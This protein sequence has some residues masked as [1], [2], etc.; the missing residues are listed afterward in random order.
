MKSITWINTIFF[1]IM[2][3]INMIANMM[4]LGGNTTGEVSARY[5][6]LFTPAPFTFMI[7]GVI[8][9]FMLLFIIAQFM[10]DKDA[11]DEWYMAKT[12]GIWFVI[13]CIFNIAWIV[14]WHFDFIIASV[15]IIV[16]L[17]ISLIV[18]STTF[19]RG[20]YHGWRLLI[21][22]GFQIYLGWICAATIANVS[23]MLKKIEWKGFGVNDQF[24]TILVLLVGSMIGILI[25]LVQHQSFSTLAICWA[26]VGILAKHL[27][28]NGYNSA[29][30][31]II[32]TLILCIVVMLLLARTFVLMDAKKKIG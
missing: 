19:K 7:W 26:Y 21:P 29:Y 4:P 5:P 27:G 1:I 22:V 24:W 13:S 3:A 9:L 16:G 23:V 8:Y 28:K 30:K 31:P 25:A 10:P 17:L 15:V 20:E 2:V 14:C 32:V 6:N 11:N 12:I 18:I